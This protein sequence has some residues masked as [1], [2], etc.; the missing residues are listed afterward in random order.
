[1]S[2]KILIV[3]SVVQKAVLEQVIFSQIADGFWKNNRKAAEHAKAWAGVRVTV[4]PEKGSKLGAVGFAVP[5]NYNFVNPAFLKACEPQMLDAA[6]TVQPDMTTKYLR[7]QLIQLSRIVGG[8]IKE[9]GGP[10]SKLNRGRK[11][12]ATPKATAAVT[13]KKAPAKIVEPVV[14]PTAETAEA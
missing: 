12:P 3:A 6:K 10:I 7:R 14:E 4:S 13:V 1:M 8:R 2:K 5:R 11:A 9:V